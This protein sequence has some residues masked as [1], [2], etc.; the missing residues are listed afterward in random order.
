VLA[1]AGLSLAAQF[2]Q[3]SPSISGWLLAGLPAI[4]FLAL[5]KLVLASPAVPAAAVDPV[6][7]DAAGEVPAADL[8]APS[9][10][11]PTAPAPAR[12]AQLVP[13]HADTFAR[14]N[15]TPVH[16]G[17]VNGGGRQ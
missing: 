4:G 16:T 14:L 2:S 13:V 9:A 6:V 5:V 15:S 12:A 1:T 8:P 10:P 17:P 7:V 3:A 11:E